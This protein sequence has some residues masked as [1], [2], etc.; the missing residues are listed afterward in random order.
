MSYNIFNM[1]GKMGVISINKL[2]V[3]V[4]TDNGKM[5]LSLSLFQQSILMLELQVSD[6]K[7]KK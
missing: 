1:S 2:T 4:D 6:G 7:I 3:H 5:S